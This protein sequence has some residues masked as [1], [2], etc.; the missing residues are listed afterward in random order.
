MAVEYPTPSLHGMPPPPPVFVLISRPL[1]L[2]NPISH[3]THMRIYLRN[4]CSSFVTLFTPLLHC[5]IVLFLNKLKF[6]FNVLHYLFYLVY[7]VYLFLFYFIFF[8]FIY[9][10]SLQPLYCIV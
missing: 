3:F 1:S 10:L 2:C 4:V 7:F 6:S 9:V 8:Y 5:I